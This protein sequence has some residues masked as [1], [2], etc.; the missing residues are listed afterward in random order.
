MVSYGHSEHTYE[1]THK[2]TTLSLL[3]TGN[4][5]SNW[6]SKNLSCLVRPQWV[7]IK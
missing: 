4:W 2:R 6:P 5:P 7:D 1:M 3:A